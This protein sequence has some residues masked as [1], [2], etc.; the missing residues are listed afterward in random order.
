MCLHKQCMNPRRSTNR[1]GGQL[2]GQRLA[3]APVCHSHRSGTGQQQGTWS[4]AGQHGTGLHTPPC[5]RQPTPST[6]PKLTPG[7]PA[8]GIF[9]QT[10][11]GRRRRARGI[12][13]FSFTLRCKIRSASQKGHAAMKCQGAPGL[14]APVEEGSKRPGAKLCA[15]T[16]IRRR[17]RQHPLH[18]EE[19]LLSSS[20]ILASAGSL[21]AA[22][23][24][25]DRLLIGALHVLQ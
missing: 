9:A 17:E 10:I 8:S 7:T 23:G 3:A 4:S 20:I 19:P 14:A 22:E 13:P 5:T 16:G 25:H 2:G 1:R 24:V 21:H 11:T 15:G 12:D 18:D 6:L